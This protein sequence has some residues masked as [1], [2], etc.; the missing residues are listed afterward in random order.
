[1]ALLL[2]HRHVLLC[3]RG[4]CPHRWWIP[5]HRCSVAWS[6]THLIISFCSCFN[7]F[8]CLPV[9][10]WWCST[11][12]Y[13]VWPHSFRDEAADGR[14]HIL[15]VLF[16]LIDHDGG[17]AAH[18]ELFSLAPVTGDHRWVGTDHHAMALVYFRSM[19]LL[20]APGSEGALHTAQQ[21]SGIPRHNSRC[22]WYRWPLEWISA[23]DNSL[24]SYSGQKRYRRC[25]RVRVFLWWWSASL[26]RSQ[27]AFFPGGFHQFSVLPNE[28]C[29]DTILMVVETEGI[30]SFQTGMSAVHSA[31]WVPGYSLIF[32]STVDTS[33]LHPTPQ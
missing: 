21:A 32:P 31:S 29:A 12:S 30:A 7:E 33:R 2:W 24:H 26:Q 14:W 15:P 10:R 17:L 3:E 9:H 4:F 25:C 11:T 8:L 18:G 6:R 28:R 22:C 23:S 5:V 19:M 13:S 27:R 16:S 20:V 1:M